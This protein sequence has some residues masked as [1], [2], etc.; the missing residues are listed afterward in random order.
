MFTR[1]A[2]LFFRKQDDEIERKKILINSQAKELE[3]RTVELNETV[4]RFAGRIECAKKEF[5]EAINDM[6]QS[7]VKRDD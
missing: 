3:Q 6:V 1:L 5:D 4:N 7:L 2:R